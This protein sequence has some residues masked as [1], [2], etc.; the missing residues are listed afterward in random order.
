MR[1]HSSYYL[2]NGNDA[3]LVP[4]QFENAELFDSDTEVAQVIPRRDGPVK[5]EGEDVFSGMPICMPRQRRETSLQLMSQHTDC[6]SLHSA[7]LKNSSYQRTQGPLPFVS[8]P[9]YDLSVPSLPS[10][11][12]VCSSPAMHQ[13]LESVMFEKCPKTQQVR[14]QSKGAPTIS[15]LREKGTRSWENHQLPLIKQFLQIKLRQEPGCRGYAASLNDRQ[16]EDST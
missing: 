13:S 14:Q 12:S 8:A 10:L 7:S 4:R 6:H 2:I 1:G 11:G 15:G 16:V 5:E 9:N 3:I